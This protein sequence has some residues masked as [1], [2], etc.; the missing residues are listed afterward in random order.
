MSGRTGMVKGPNIRLLMERHGIQTAIYVGD[1]TGDEQASRLAGIPFVWASYG[2][3]RADAPDAVIDSLPVL[4]QTAA[5]LLRK[6]V[7]ST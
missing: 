3:G 7:S 4:P 6:P 2:F 1:T 5:A